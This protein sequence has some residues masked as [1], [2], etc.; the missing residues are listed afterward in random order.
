MAKFAFESGVDDGRPT[1]RALLPFLIIAVVLISALGVPTSRLEGAL[2]ALALGTFVAAVVVQAIAVRRPR[3]SAL[4]PVGSWLFFAGVFALEFIATGSTLAVAPLIVLPLLWLALF[5]QRIHLVIACV[6]SAVALLLPFA[7]AGPGGFETHHLVTALGLCA[8]V[9][10]VTPVV[11]GVVRELHE[12]RRREH[13]ASAQLRRVME[14]ATLSA[15]ISTDAEGTITSF[16]RGAELL[17]GYSASEVIGKTTPD[18]FLASADVARVAASLG[19]PPGL[20]VI[21]KLAGLQEPARTWG[22][23]RKDG[24]HGHLRLVVT[25]LTDE[26]GAV[27]GYLGV[28]IDATAEVAAGAALRRSEARW[29]IAMQHL[30]D[31][32]VLVLDGEMRVRMSAGA[33]ALR[34]GMGE[35]T[36]RLL[37]DVINPENVE[38]L[39]P[40]VVNALQEGIDGRSEI[41]ATV[42]GHEHDVWVSPLPPEPEAEPEVMIAARDISEQRAREREIVRARDRAERLFLDAPHGIVLL[43]TDGFVTAVNPSFA[44]LSA[45]SEDELLGVEL[46]SL[47]ASDDNVLSQHLSD[48]LR[49]PS[50]RSTAEWTLHTA[51]DRIVHVGLSSILLGSTEGEPDQVLVNVIDNSE[52]YRLESQ[53]TQMSEHDPLT[54]LVNRRRFSVELGSH[55]EYCRRYGYRG[56]LLLMDLD[57]FKEIN[58]TLGHNAGDELIVSVASVLRS[59]VR[60]TDVVCRLGGDEFAV[61]LRETDRAGAELVAETVINQVREYARSLEGNHRDITASVGVVMV[62]ERNSSPGDLLAAADMTMYDAK[63]AGR[64]RWALLDY[65][66]FDLPRVGARMAWNTRIERAIENDDLALHLQPIWDMKLGRVTGAEVLLRLADG[67]TLVYPSRFLYVAEHT[68]LIKKLDEWVLNKSLGILKRLQ[69]LEPTFHLEVNVSGKS[70]GDTRLEKTLIAALNHHDVDPTG[71]VL[72][73]TET[74]AVADIAAARAFAQRVTALGCRF[75]LDDFGAGFGSFYYLKHLIFDYVKIDGEFVST[76]HLS[77]TD[78]A[79]VHAIVGIAH[80]LGK[81]TIAEFVCDDSIMEVIEA[82]DV[83]FAQGYHIGKPIELEKFVETFLRPAP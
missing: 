16:S 36:G 74:A 78:R 82:E 23:Q 1:L 65:E 58:D 50:G 47:E 52:R 44:L 30:P 33:G 72:E 27:C 13:A 37:A 80:G 39:T 31:T 70:I 24:A 53:M 22:Y 19:V 26:A 71:L 83:D 46:A 60:G 3:R 67:P 68:G 54:G 40:L 32:T 6:L 73:I 75:A 76:C 48:V 57:H 5:G 38:A 81:R 62:D 34:S 51:D 18:S 64:D 69:T 11:H 10:V 43:D 25:D 77:P 29:R 41:T 55:L 63:D 7:L 17:S 2:P 66:L 14:A 8:L 21:Q 59:T 4:D 28:A 15:I 42:N 61:L 79:I 56:A 35:V 12:R 45:R 9:F 49:A 20:P